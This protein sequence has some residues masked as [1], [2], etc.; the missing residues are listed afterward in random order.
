MQDFF[1]AGWL[2]AYFFAALWLL[3]WLASAH[4]TSVSQDTNPLKK[5]GGIVL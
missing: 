3:G 2:V 1:S 4:E 5:L